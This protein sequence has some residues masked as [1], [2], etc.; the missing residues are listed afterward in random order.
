MVD[1]IDDT[2]SISIDVTYPEGVADIHDVSYPST[3][4][5]GEDFDITY[6]VTNTSSQSDTLWGVLV[7]DGGN[8]IAG[9]YWS[10]TV[11][12]GATVS[13]TITMNISEPFN[14]ALQAGHVE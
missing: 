9:T 2:H 10:E 14:G 1:V 13:K 12:A 11:A 3:V 6:Q 5:A 4:V 8:P 7:D